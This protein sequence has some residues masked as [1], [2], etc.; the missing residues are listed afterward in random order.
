MKIYIDKTKTKESYDESD[1]ERSSKDL[2]FTETSGNW[3]FGHL[4]EQDFTR[5]FLDKYHVTESRCGY[6]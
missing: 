1:H 4:E 6:Q 3:L 2:L 5:T